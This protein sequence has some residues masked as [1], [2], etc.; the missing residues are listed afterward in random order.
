MHHRE[1]QHAS[2]SRACGVRHTRAEDE[3]VPWHEEM[4]AVLGVEDDLPLEQVNRDRPLRVMRWQGAACGKRDQR[5]AQRPVLHERSRASPMPLQQILIYRLDIAP[6][7]MDLD[8]P[9][10]DPSQRRHDTSLVGEPTG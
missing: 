1:Q 6:Q 9:I 10:D 8:V 3:H 2:F 5:Q 7:M 4:L